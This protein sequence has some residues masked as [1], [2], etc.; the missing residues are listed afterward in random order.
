MVRSC[1][2]DLGRAQITAATDGVDATADDPRD[3]AIDGAR[4]A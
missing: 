2:C 4:A 1:R 3:N